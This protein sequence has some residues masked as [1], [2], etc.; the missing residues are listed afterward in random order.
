LPGEPPSEHGE[1][2]LEPEAVVTAGIYI[3]D[4]DFIPFSP[5]DRAVRHCG[6]ICKRLTYTALTGAELPQTC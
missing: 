6:I 4:L 1:Q 3:T 2:R 5:V